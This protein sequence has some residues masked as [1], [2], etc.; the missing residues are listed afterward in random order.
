MPDRGY[1]FEGSPGSRSLVVTGPWSELAARALA[2][3]EADGLVLNY[4][5]GFC[6]GSLEM[7]D[8]SWPLRRLSVLDR[9][10]VDLDPVGRLSGLEELSVQAAA[11]AALDLGMLLG[12]R[13]LSGAWELIGRT[14]SA[15][16]ELEAVTTWMFGDSDMHAFRDHYVLRRLTIKDAPHLVSV[17]GL[18]NLSDLAALKIVGAA[19]LQE[20]DAIAEL[21]A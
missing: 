6:E 11:A 13:S 1:V 16:A 18:G 10:I 5:R 15:A 12:L 9:S 17:A 3:G 14:I 21:T 8:G 4:A 2:R 19:R 20:L 7:L